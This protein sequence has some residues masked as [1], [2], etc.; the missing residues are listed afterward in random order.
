MDKYQEEF[1]E[2]LTLGPLENMEMG[3]GL[4]MWNNRMGGDN[5]VAS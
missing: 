4:Y 5:H 1:R 3:D 2:I